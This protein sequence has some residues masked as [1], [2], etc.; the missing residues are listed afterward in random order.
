M[1]F[2]AKLNDKNTVEAFGL[3]Y[4]NN[5]RKLTMDNSSYLVFFNDDRDCIGILPIPTNEEKKQLLHSLQQQAVDIVKTKDVNKIM[6]IYLSYLQDYSLY[7]AGDKKLPPIDNKYKEYM[8]T[9]LNEY[10]G[11]IDRIHKYLVSFQQKPNMQ[12]ANYVTR[13]FKEFFYNDHT[14]KTLDISQ[15]SQFIMGTRKYE[16]LRK[17]F[18]T[19]YKGQLLK[20]NAI[21]KEE[22][23]SNSL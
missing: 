8:K 13:S 9:V 16:D 7:I 22:D 6:Q 5:L 20:T 15:L 11:N 4:G 1:K 3:E 21:S 12:D 19:F 2:V 14:N 10:Y 18:E 17:Q 23:Q